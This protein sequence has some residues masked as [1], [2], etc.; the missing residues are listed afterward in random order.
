M[1]VYKLLKINL[2]VRWNIQF[3]HDMT[4]WGKSESKLVE[5]ISLLRIYIIVM[6]PMITL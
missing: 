5:T 6:L 3:S 1:Y 4:T 2:F